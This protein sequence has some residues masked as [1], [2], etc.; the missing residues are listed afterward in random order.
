LQ[1]IDWALTSDRRVWKRDALITL[2]GTAGMLLVLLLF[3]PQEPGEN[4]S[5]RAALLQVAYYPTAIATFYGWTK[6]LVTL[7]R[8]VSRFIRHL[9]SANPDALVRLYEL[10]HRF[11]AASFAASFFA[12]ISIGD[13]PLANWS[14]GS[15]RTFAVGFGVL[16]VVFL[17]ELLVMLRNRNFDP[18]S[19]HE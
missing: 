12:A 16:L 17:P 9:R 6:F 1:L 4:T 14:E 2:V 15:R 19:E 13:S 7:E 5:S 11:A 3:D 8:P 18:S 10:C